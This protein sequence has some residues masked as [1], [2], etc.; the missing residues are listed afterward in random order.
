MA[1]LIREAPVGQVIRWLTKAKYLKY[2]EELPGFEVPA[3]YNAVL[4]EKPGSFSGSEAP[5]PLVL[6]KTKSSRSRKTLDEKSLERDPL[7]I[8][9][10]S[11]RSHSDTDKESTTDGPIYGGAT[12]G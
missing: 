11:L 8:E 4:N 2:P 5:T 3:T 12:R 6:E 1:D 7:D 9:A 10:A